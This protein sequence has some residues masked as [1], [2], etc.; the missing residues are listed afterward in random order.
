MDKKENVKQKKK[1]YKTIIDQIT[2][3]FLPIINYLTAASILKSVVILLANFGVLSKESGAYILFYAVSDGFFYFLP[4]LLA[5][6][7]SKQW[8]TDLFI[9]ILIPIAMLYPDV[10][11]ILENG[12]T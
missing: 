11:A 9:S 10:S 2:G 7:A 12:N 8:K 6:T 4:M 5:I 1:V 3:I